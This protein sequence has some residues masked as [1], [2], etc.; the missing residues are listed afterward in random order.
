MGSLNMVSQ[1]F[2]WF[3][4]LVAPRFFALYWNL[5][6]QILVVVARNLL[7]STICESTTNSFL[8]EI[9]RGCQHSWKINSFWVLGIWWWWVTLR[10]LFIASTFASFRSLL[11]DALIFQKIV[12][13]HRLYHV[14]HFLLELELIDLGVKD[15]WAALDILLR[16]LRWRII[17]LCGKTGDLSLASV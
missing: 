3:E 10:M 14:F 11:S 8:A 13:L 5:D 16:S 7:R 6:F 4:N 12:I 2:F 9:R 1:R 17:E 15:W